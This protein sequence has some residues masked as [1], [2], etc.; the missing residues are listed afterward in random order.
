MPHRCKTERI[1]TYHRSVWH[2]EYNYDVLCE[3][4]PWNLTEFGII[5]VEIWIATVKLCYSL[6]CQISPWSMRHVASY[7]WR[8][9]TNFITF[10]NSTF[11][12]GAIAAQRKGWTGVHVYKPSSI[13][14]HQN[15]FGLTATPL[16]PKFIVVRKRDGHANTE[17]SLAF[18]WRV[19]CK[20]H[21]T[22][23]DEY[24]S[25]ITFLEI[26][27]NTKWICLLGAIMSLCE[28]EVPRVS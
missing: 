16:S 23:R 3:I 28:S 21:H 2:Y 22:R 10:W 19:Q 27:Y 24:A 9:T 26:Q 7:A 5:L 20:L 11:C 25:L 18:R 6:P 13:Q 1:S 15:R 17:P 4:S 12:D 8:K 14:R